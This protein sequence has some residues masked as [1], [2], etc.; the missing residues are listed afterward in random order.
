MLGRNDV[1]LVFYFSN[2]FSSAL[3]EQ[4]H[5]PQR[6]QTNTNKLNEPFQSESRTLPNNEHHDETLGLDEE[7][8]STPHE[9]EVPTQPPP[10]QTLEPRIVAPHVVETHSETVQLGSFA[11][12]DRDT[13]TPTDDS[14]TQSRSSQPPV[15]QTDRDSKENL[16]NLDAMKDVIEEDET[17][18]GVSQSVLDTVREGQDMTQSPLPHGQQELAG[19]SVGELPTADPLQS[20][21]LESKPIVDE[22]DPQSSLESVESESVERLHQGD[23]EQQFEGVPYQPEKRNEPGDEVGEEDAAGKETPVPGESG[24]AAEVEPSEEAVMGEETVEKEPGEGEGRS[25]HLLKFSLLTL[26]GLRT[27]YR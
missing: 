13:S 20:K 3:A 27:A 4:S 18:N 23:Q 17:E 22:H 14:R 24:D 5:R 2:C 25:Q 7:S 21:F 6:S 1:S 26:L 19:G 12:R 9:Q 15:E 8:T 11:S 16:E 10:K